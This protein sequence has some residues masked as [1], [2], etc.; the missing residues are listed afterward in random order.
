M[1]TWYAIRGDD[2]MALRS[3]DSFVFPS[4]EKPP[5]EGREIPL[6]SDAI[7]LDID[8]TTEPPG[9]Y[10][11]WSLRTIGLAIGRDAFAD[12]DR[13]AQF[14]R[15]ERTHRFCGVCSSPMAHAKD[16]TG[17][18]CGGCGFSAWPRLS[19]A[20]IVRVTRGDKLLLARSPRFPTPLYSVLAGFVEPGESIE[21]CVRREVMEEVGISVTNIR[22]FGSQS[23]PFPH[24]LMIGMTADW[25][26]GELRPD[27]AEI[28]DCDWYSRDCELPDLPPDL[29][30]ARRLI[31]AYL[32]GSA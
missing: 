9:E 1:T 28:V 13:A 10:A 25:E 20:M 8:D 5:L 27:P 4:G 21:D 12:C 29:S 2:L 3:G 32:T 30:I 23:W 15:F 22:Y 14:V 24:S 6:G 26:S 31:D 11:F 19:P 16:D 7:A 18:R 17:V